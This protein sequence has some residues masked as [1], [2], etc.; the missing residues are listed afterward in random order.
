MLGKGLPSEFL[1]FLSQPGLSWEDPARPTEG[2]TLR[3]EGHGMCQRSLSQLQAQ[4]GV[5]SQADRGKQRNIGMAG[6]PASKPRSKE[7]SRLSSEPGMKGG[8]PQGVSWGR[9][10][11]GSQGSP[12]R[13]EAWPKAKYL[14]TDFWRSMHTHVCKGQ[15]AG[16]HPSLPAC[17]RGAWA[18]PS[19]RKAGKYTLRW[20]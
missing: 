2:S 15:E 13:A 5:L 11:R 8:H 1:G 20:A 16:A 3:K 17:S 19:P 14:S 9:E 10:Q 7:L 4:S 12:G 18:T 6:G